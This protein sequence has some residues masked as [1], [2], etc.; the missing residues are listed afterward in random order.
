LLFLFVI[1]FSILGIFYLNGVFY[2]SGKAFFD[3]LR[4]AVTLWFILLYRYE[5]KFFGKN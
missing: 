3:I 4:R 2:M 5:K 1:Y